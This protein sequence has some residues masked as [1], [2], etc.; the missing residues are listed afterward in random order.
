MKKLIFTL[1]IGVLILSGCSKKNNT[2]IDDSTGITAPSAQVDTVDS[3]NEADAD[4]AEL[5]R[6]DSLRQ[7]SILRESASHEALQKEE[8]NKSLPNVDKIYSDDNPI[9]EKYLKSLGYIK[10][11]KNNN[12]VFKKEVGHRSCI[13]EFSRGIDSDGRDEANIWITIN[14]DKE[15]LENLYRKTKPLENQSGGDLS[16][17]VSKTKNTILISSSW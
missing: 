11:I 3:A 15:A 8:F 5:A 16:V 9:R 12:V 14:G 6:L 4:S 2:H 7:D 10:S 17:G 1:F 13:L